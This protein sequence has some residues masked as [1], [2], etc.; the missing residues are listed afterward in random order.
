MLSKDGK[1]LKIFEKFKAYEEIKSIGKVLGR[2]AFGEVREINYN[3]KMLAGKLLE[4]DKNEKSPEE[5]YF[6][7]LRGK[8]IINTMI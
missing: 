7:E 5:I 1:Y 3:N 8:N 4:K 6:S 2:G